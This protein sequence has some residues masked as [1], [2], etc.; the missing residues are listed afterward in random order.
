MEWGP[1]NIRVNCIAPGLVRTDFARALWENPD[2]LAE[3]CRDKQQR[4]II[5]FAA[6]SHDLIS[7]ARQKIAKKGCDLL[8]ANDISVS[9]SGFDSDTNTVV[10]VAPNGEIEELPPLPKASV[11]AQLLDRVGKL[12]G[13]QN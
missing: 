13:E 11:A 4:V 3:L 12:R 6:E 2:I 5:G 9:G 7:R 1:Q 8:V 10:F